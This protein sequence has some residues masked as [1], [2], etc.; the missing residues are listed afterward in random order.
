MRLSFNLISIKPKFKIQFLK[1]NL[2]K[3]AALRAKKSAKR[4]FFLFVCFVLFC[5]L[6]S[7]SSKI[8]VV[9]EKAGGKKA[10]KKK[11]GEQ[12]IF[13]VKFLVFILATF[14]WPQNYLL[15]E[16]VAVWQ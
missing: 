3:F 7:I 11:G 9:K 2:A 10:G 15:T 14:V 16:E 13:M 5:F 4:P 6:Y 8:T 12:N 1:M